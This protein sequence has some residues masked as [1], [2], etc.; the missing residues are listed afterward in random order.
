MDAYS[1]RYSERN[2]DDFFLKF[3][4]VRSFTADSNLLHI[5]MSHVT[6]AQEFCPHHVIHA[7]C[8]VVGLILFD[9]PHSSPSLSSSFSFSCSSSS[10][11]MWGTSTL[12]T[13]AN[14]DLGTLSENDPLT[15]YEPNDLH[16]SETTDI[17]I[18]QSSGD[19]RSLNLHDLEFDD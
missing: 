18:Q 7:S 11:M 3:V 4:V 13:L 10:S 9:S 5:S 8:A 2:F 19:N 14:E 17:F 12:R 16:N 15:G 1:L 6:Q